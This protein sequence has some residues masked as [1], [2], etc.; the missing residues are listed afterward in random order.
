M[1]KKTDVI[2][3]PEKQALTLVKYLPVLP[4]CQVL[5]NFTEGN[6]RK[7]TVSVAFCAHVKVVN[8]RKTPTFSFKHAQIT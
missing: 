2:D 4:V 7:F 1:F 8:Y 3:F 5:Q 6:M